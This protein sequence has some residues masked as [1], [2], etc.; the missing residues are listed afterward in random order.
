MKTFL[1]IAALTL[2]AGTANA[3]CI[4]NWVGG[5]CGTP[6]ADVTGQRYARYYL[7]A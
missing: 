2:F 7:A 3:S 5:A 1:T 6:S 4:T